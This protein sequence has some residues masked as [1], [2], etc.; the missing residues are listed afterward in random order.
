[1]SALYFLI[2]VKL[3]KEEFITVKGKK[4]GSPILIE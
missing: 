1:M 2:T 4:L 3:W